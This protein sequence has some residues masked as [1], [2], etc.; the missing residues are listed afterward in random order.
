MRRPP[1]DR[2]SSGATGFSTLCD[3]DVRG[4]GVDVAELGRIEGVL[5]L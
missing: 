5:S 2:P 1:A 3:V 4:I